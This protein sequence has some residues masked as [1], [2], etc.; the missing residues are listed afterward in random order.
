MLPKILWSYLDDTNDTTLHH[1]I[2]KIDIS[3]YYGVIL[4]QLHE[5]KLH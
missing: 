1:N 2:M 3:H 4:D 5:L